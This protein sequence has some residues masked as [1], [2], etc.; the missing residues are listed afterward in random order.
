MKRTAIADRLRVLRKSLN[1]NQTEFAK[2]LGVTFSAISLME[3]G[4]TNLTD[5]NIN[6]IR[7]TFGV[8][9]EWLRSGEGE[10]FNEEALL[11]DLDKRALE[12]FHRLSPRAQDLAIGYLEKILADEQILR[13]EAPYRGR[14]N[15]S[16]TDEQAGE[17]SSHPIHDQE[18]A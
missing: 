11:D 17:K 12:L 13:E 5:Q 2:R 6:L 8:N 16:L 18:R 7:L 1:L 9:E 10:M 3:L 15:A 14:K 4:K